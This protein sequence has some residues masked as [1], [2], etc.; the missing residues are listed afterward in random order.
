MV[1]LDY[2]LIL[3]ETLDAGNQYNLSSEIKP[4]EQFYVTNSFQDQCLH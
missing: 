2:E 3:D 4:S 1:I